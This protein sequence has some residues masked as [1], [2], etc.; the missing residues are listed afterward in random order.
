METLMRIDI[1]HELIRRL[2]EA[3]AREG[4]FTESIA[5]QV[6]RTFRQEYGG[7]EYYIKKLPAAMAD[8]KAA[9]TQAYLNGEPTDRIASEHGIDR[10]TLYRYLKRP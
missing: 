6:E 2:L 4:T 1:A 7:D 8:K 10:A 9:I 3:A 5:L